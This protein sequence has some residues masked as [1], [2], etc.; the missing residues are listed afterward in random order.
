MLSNEKTGIAAVSYKGALSLEEM[1][2]DVTAHDFGTLEIKGPLKQFDT[3]AGVLCE[4]RDGVIDRA[5]LEKLRALPNVCVHSENVTFIN[6]DASINPDAVEALRA[7]IDLCALCGNGGTVTVHLLPG[8]SRI[9]GVHKPL[10]NPLLPAEYW[11]VSVKAFKEYGRYAED[12]NVK[13]GIETFVPIQHGNKAGQLIDEIG[14]P[15]VG[16]TFDIGHFWA[17]FDPD[18]WCDEKL[19]PYYDTDKGVEMMNELMLDFAQCFLPQVCHM[20]VHD[21]ARCAVL[22]DHKPLGTGVMPLDKLFSLVRDS[23][24]FSGTVVIETGVVGKEA[25]DQSC[26]FLSTYL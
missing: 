8:Y 15:A 18:D 21:V 12:R 22:C 23:K 2:A 19:T 17:I 11:D 5:M 1:I 13:I 14:S 24:D 7:S 10:E 6:P 20:H 9:I 4:C 25:I 16:I 3:K 26:N